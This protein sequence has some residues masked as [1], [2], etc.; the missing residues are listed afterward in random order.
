MSKLNLFHPATPRKTNM[1]NIPWTPCHG[2]P[3]TPRNTCFVYSVIKGWSDY[4]ACRTGPSESSG[5]GVM[6]RL[7]MGPGYPEQVSIGAGQA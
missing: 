3:A 7:R 2:H 6:N 1:H 5:L 4:L